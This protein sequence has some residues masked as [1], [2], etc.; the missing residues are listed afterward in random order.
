M[1]KDE[2]VVWFK[3]ITAVMFPP[4]KEALWSNLNCLNISLTDKASEL[5][6]QFLSIFFFTNQLIFGFF[7]SHHAPPWPDFWQILLCTLP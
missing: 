3:K 7:F 5:P 2:E 6:M 4:L 1:N